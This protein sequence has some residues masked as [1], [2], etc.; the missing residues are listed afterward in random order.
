M[1]KTSEIRIR[2]IPK[3]P[4]TRLGEAMGRHS[5]APF[6]ALLSDSA[7]FSR[8][9]NR[10]FAGIGF[11][12]PRF[13]PVHACFIERVQ[14]FP[15]TDVNSCGFNEAAE[16]ISRKSNCRP[17]R[18][19]SLNVNARCCRQTTLGRRPERDE[20]TGA[21]VFPPSARYRQAKCSASTV[22]GGCSS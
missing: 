4:F 8:F 3:A 2:N 9:E 5:I 17:C 20:M 13:S 21:A 7:G 6:L 1:P 14:N 22:D 15:A 10:R 19:G 18:G 12:K 11:K 16:R